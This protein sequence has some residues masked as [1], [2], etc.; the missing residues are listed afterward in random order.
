MELIMKTQFTFTTQQP[1]EIKSSEILLTRATRSSKKEGKE[2]PAAFKP[3]Y[4]VAEIPFEIQNVANEFVKLAALSGLQAAYQKAVT[5][6]LP[7]D[8]LKTAN[9]AEQIISITEAELKSILSSEAGDARRIT[10]EQITEAWKIVVSNALHNLCK[11]RGVKHENHL[12]DNVR[13]QVGARLQKRA[14]FLLS[15]ASTTGVQLYSEEQLTSELEWLIALVEKEQQA[16][17]GSWIFSACLEKVSRRLEKLAEMR[18]AAEAE[19][20]SNEEELIDLDSLI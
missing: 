13:R 3:M 4:A 20:T 12:P 19:E 8:L 16:A 10:K 9:G 17:D 15:L 2:I 11:L 6:K 1:Q 18:E 7:A 14:D 5:Q